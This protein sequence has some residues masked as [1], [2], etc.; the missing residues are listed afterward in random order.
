MIKLYAYQKCGTCVKAIQWLQ[1]HQIAFEVYPIR[2]VSPSESELQ[3]ALSFYDG[4]VHPLFNKSGKDYREMGLKNRLG[5]LSHSDVIS[6]LRSNGNLIKRPFV[7]DN[8]RAWVGFKADCWE[9][10]LN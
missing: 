6:L 3:L 2:E 9:V 8:G 10:L 1:S 5:S 7:V 4:D